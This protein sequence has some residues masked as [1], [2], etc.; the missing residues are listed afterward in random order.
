MNLAVSHIDGTGWTGGTVY[1]KNLLIA[2]KS[3]D[4]AERPRVRLLTSAE[5]DPS[6]YATLLPYT[7]GVLMRPRYPSKRSLPARLYHRLRRTKG[8]DKLMESYLKTSGIDCIFGVESYG[9]GFDLPVLTWLPDFQHLHRPEM[10]SDA[11]IEQR[12][13]SFT[14]AAENAV[15]VVVSSRDALADFERFAPAQAH[16]GRVLSFVAQVPSDIYETDPSGV[17]QEYN[18]PERFLYLPNQFW[19]H[20]NHAVVIEALALLKQQNPEVTVVCTG[21]TQDYRNSHYFANLMTEIARQGLRNQMIIL[22]L[23]PHAHTFQLMRQSLAV[24][25]PSL[26]EGWSTTVEEAKSVGKPMLLSSLPVHCEQNPP[27]SVYF[28]PS[29]AVSL[30][31]KMHDLYRTNT[32]G[33]NQHLEEQA[34]ACLEQ[35]TQEFGKTFMA[36]MR[37]VVS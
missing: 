10:F 7:D 27:A 24:L 28:E 4:E 23:V 30:A 3:L 18:L 5:T 9:P 13:R 16:K 20:K 29:A 14:E 35:R 22:G 15:R 31:Q 34:R 26:F 25:Q 11:E 1:L 36:I 33:P 32:P 17:C 2:L 6:S 21:N 12:N 19:K 37:E 8:Q